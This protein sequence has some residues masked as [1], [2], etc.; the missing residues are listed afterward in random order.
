[1]KKIFQDCM[2]AVIF[3]AICSVI[4]VIMGLIEAHDKKKKDGKR[5]FGPTAIVI[6]TAEWIRRIMKRTI[7][8]FQGAVQRRRDHAVKFDDV[9]HRLSPEMMAAINNAPHYTMEE[10][11]NGITA[12]AKEPIIITD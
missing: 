1:M 12:P 6:Y 8:I 10:L 3:T 11:E 9:V 2:I 4:A 5:P 7:G